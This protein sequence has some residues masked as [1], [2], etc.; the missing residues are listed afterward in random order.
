M[1]N[2][3]DNILLHI[4][5]AVRIDVASIP[6]WR[7]LMGRWEQP[8][9][10]HDVAEFISHI[11]QSAPIAD[12]TGMWSAFQGERN[13]DESDLSK[14]VLP[15][16]VSRLRNIQQCIYGTKMVKPEDFSLSPQDL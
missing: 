2:S 15:L 14:T 12:M 8:D 6:S 9:S 7:E 4:S 16:V 13:T 3:L 1:P 10:Q 11:C 5:N